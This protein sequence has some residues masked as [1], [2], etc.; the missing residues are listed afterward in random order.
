MKYYQFLLTSILFISFSFIS[1]A[2]FDLLDKVK[3]KVQDKIEQKTD[4]AIDSTLEGKGKN[5][6]VQK[7]NE[8]TEQKEVKQEE[9]N[10]TTTKP[11][12][13][14]LKVYSKF[15][16]VPGEQIIFYEDFAQDNVGDFPGKWNTNGSGEV[17]TF[18]KY[19]GK[20]LNIKMNGVFYPELKNKFPDN[21]TVEF[22]M[23]YQVD[24]SK[25]SGNTMEI[26]FISTISGERIDG[27]VPG[28]GGF[29]IQATNHDCS[30]FN[31]AGGQYSDIQNSKDITTF[32]EFNGKPVRVSIWVQKQRM[33]LYIN[34]TKVFDI[35]RLVPP[36]IVI[37]RARFHEG[38]EQEGFELYVTNY[39]IA[40]GAPDT[41]NKLITEGKLVTRG[42]HFDSGSDKIKSE[43]YGTL[44]EIAQVLKENSTVKVKIVGHT[45]T[46][47]NEKS[48]LDLSKRRAASIKN[49]LNGEF[50][51]DASRMETDGKGQS[52]PV[53][54]NSTPEGKSNNRRVEFI[55]L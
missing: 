45:D 46:D 39:R 24:H 20:W 26:D 43:S 33:R 13:E 23:I 42:I 21:Y 15:D 22:D 51:I 12:E 3:E 50:G 47:G 28:N 41:R 40:F 30:V 55:K 27:L 35:P 37:D 34:E 54:D 32:D 17:V 18:N 2:Q 49:A 7:N 48:N 14:D 4:Q 53:S 44:K 52:Q 16:F 1:Y 25:S 38:G 11:K 31:W 29:A 8:K 6:D 19:P 5:V 9:Q 36:G 10:S